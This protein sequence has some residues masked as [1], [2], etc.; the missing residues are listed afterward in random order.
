MWFLDFFFAWISRNV[1]K[2]SPT[3]EKTEG[4]QYCIKLKSDVFIIKK[5]Q[6]KQTNK[7]Q[8][9]P[10]RRKF[11]HLFH[12]YNHCLGCMKWIPVCQTQKCPW[13][14]FLPSKLPT[15]IILWKLFAIFSA[16]LLLFPLFVLVFRSSLRKHYEEKKTF[17][18]SSYFNGWA[19]S[20][21]QTHL[22]L[23]GTSSL[24]VPA[25]LW[26]VKNK[27]GIVFLSW[28]SRTAR[29]ITQVRDQTREIICKY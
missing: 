9:L 21:Q 6:P 8:T 22:F 15:T 17:F 26:K 16:T 29:K 3:R 20:N 7:I 2:W 25:L 24:T 5:P 10:F 19:N 27:I 14:V 11:L 12:T 4:K 18:L 23:Y 1:T 13:K 28:N